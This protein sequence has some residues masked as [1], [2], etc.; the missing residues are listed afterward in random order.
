MILKK[1][2]RSRI[3]QWLWKWLHPDIGVGLAAG[4][5]RRSRAYTSD[6]NYGNEKNGLTD[7]AQA[8]IMNEDVDFVIMGHLHQPMRHEFLKKDGSLGVYMNLGDWLGHDTFGMFDG[9]TLTLASVHDFLK[10][11]GEH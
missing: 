10:K 1:I 5:S 4:V 8:K 2:L 7:F 11:V 6:K 3:N 9:Y